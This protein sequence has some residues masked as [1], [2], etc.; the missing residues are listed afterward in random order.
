MALENGY[1]ARGSHL[2]ATLFKSFRDA[3]SLARVGLVSKHNDPR[4]RGLQAEQVLTIARCSLKFVA[5][6]FGKDLPRARAILNVY[7]KR[8][9]CAN[10][11]LYTPLA[12]EMVGCLTI[13]PET[14]ANDFGVLLE[15][16]SRFDFDCRRRGN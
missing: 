5:A 1:Y 12:P 11:K 13:P 3:E 14:S 7:G 8:S 6:A 10:A 2:E 4:G 15:L 16:I 9:R